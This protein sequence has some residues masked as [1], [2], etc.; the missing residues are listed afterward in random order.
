MRASDYLYQ[1]GCRLH[2]SNDGWTKMLT[3][4]AGFCFLMASQ[5]FVWK[6]HL[7]F[8]AAVL[9]TRIRDRGNEPR[10]DEI[11]ILDTVFANDKLNHLFT[12]ETYHVIDFDQEFDSGFNSALF[13]EYDSTMARFFNVDCNTTSG[14]YKFGDVES[15]ATMTLDFKTMPF[16]HTKFEFTE[17]F[18]IYDL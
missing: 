12:P 7:V 5:A 6:L 17:P 4:Y 2:R 10:A 16:S 1:I 14:F 18:L 15:G 11:N 3:G 8:G 9:V 13:P